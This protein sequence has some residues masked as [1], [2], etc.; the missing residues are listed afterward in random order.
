MSSVSAG[1]LCRFASAI[2]HTGNVKYL[3]ARFVQVVAILCTNYA[4][5]AQRV[6]IVHKINKVFHAI[7]AIS[8]ELQRLGAVQ[9][10]IIR[11][12]ISPEHRQPPA[13]GAQHGARLAADR[14]FQV[15]ACADRD[16]AHFSSVALARW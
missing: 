4:I 12:N 1:L 6:H 13:F 11:S 15:D 10:H 16:I 14:I 5:L 8:R 3:R 7:N 9:T 2:K